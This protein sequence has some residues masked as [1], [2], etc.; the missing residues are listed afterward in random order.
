MTATQRQPQRSVTDVYKALGDAVREMC[1]ILNKPT[2]NDPR[3]NFVVVDKNAMERIRIA[4]IAAGASLR[5]V[6][7]APA[8]SAAAMKKFIETFEGEVT[9]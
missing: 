7:A 2:A 8:V 4:M 9:H 6:E 5:K 1:D 3:H